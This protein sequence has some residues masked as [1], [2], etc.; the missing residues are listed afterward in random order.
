MKKA[1]INLL[2]VKTLLS[3]MVVGVTCYMAVKGSIDSATFIALASAIVTYYFTRNE[4]K[5][6]ETKDE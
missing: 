3:L 4:K 5:E 2:K 1:L 6:E